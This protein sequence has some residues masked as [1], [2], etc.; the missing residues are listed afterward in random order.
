MGEGAT[1]VTEVRSPT[2]RRRELGTRL[3]ALRTEADLTVE[4]VAERLLCS[5]SK[6]SRLETGARGA[7]ARDIRDLC[8]LY[9]MTGA[10][11][12]H[13]T[14][15]AKEGRD[16]AWWQ[17]FDLPYATYVGLEAAAVLISDYEPGGVPALLQT[18]AYARA[19][20]ESAWPPLSPDVI[21]QR[22]ESRRLRQD[23]LSRE[24]PPH[25]KAVIDEAVLHRIVGG[26]IVM[27]EQLQWMIEANGMAQV[28]VRVLPY[29][30]GSHPAL[31]STFVIL[32][33]AA[34]VPGVVY[35]DGLV[36]QIYLERP[37]DFDR[38]KEVFERLWELSLGAGESKKLTE[39][40]RNEYAKK[41][42]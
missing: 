18:P 24:E 38:Y 25:L 31:D 42:K 39:K 8:D 5:P 35:V 21:E 13:L 1:G 11:R 30:A 16:Q 34:P 7:S 19:V 6:I 17:P 9:E 10:E 3:R 41:R 2:V 28:D 12:E 15:L 26:P 37:Q 20:H 29:S 32:E 36:G 4:Q 40:M 23:V 33:F 27:H 22:I 14:A